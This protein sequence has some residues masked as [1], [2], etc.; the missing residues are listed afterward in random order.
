[1]P[2]TTR[3]ALR[4]KELAEEEAVEASVPLPPTPQ[5]ERVPLGEIANNKVAGLILTDS[6]ETEPVKQGGKKG[7]KPKGAKKGGK[8]AMDITG[9]ADVE[10]MEDDNQSSASSAAEEA[11]E[12]LIITQGTKP[13]RKDD[14]PRSLIRLPL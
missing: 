11:R 7:R 10:I 5:K 2:R 13:V 4:S 1:M 12:E 9:N 8:R 6:A 14:L 3:A